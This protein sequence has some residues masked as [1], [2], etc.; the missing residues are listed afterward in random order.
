ML[1]NDLISLRAPEPE[2]LEL[3]Y[4]WENDPDI[5]QVSNTLAPFSRFELKQYL[6]STRK[7]LYEARQLRLM[8]DVTA[9][10][11]QKTVGT[12]D[13]FEFEPYHNR[14]G[15][16]ILIADKAERGKGYASAALDLLIDYTFNHLSLHQ[17]FCNISADNTNSIN[18]F[19]NKGFVITGEKTDWL[20]E[21]NQ[22]KN[23]YTLQLLNKTVTGK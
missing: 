8:I 22:W 18:L 12:I 20:W 1:K 14:A 23:E 11:P 2:D 17:L 6:E 16:G 3:L 10:T 4:I 19:K 5:W 7:D 15:V 13:L 9:G 21:N